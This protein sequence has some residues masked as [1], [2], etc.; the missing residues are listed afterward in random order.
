MTDR[1]GDDRGDPVYPGQEPTGSGQQGGSASY[2]GPPP[3]YPGQ[4]PPPPYGGYGSAPAQPGGYG[5]APVPPGGYGQ[6]PVYP[7]GGYDGA[8]PAAG[9]SGWAIAAFVCSLI[10]FLGILAAVPLAIVALVKISKTRQRGKF[11]AIAAMI[12]SVLW[13]VGAVGL[14]VAWFNNT[15]GRDDQGVI[16]EAG[17]LELQQIRAGDCVEI[18][19]LSDSE[20][21]VSAYEISGLPCDEPHNA[22]AVAVIEIQGEEFPGGAALDA[23]SALLCQ[24]KYSESFPTDF[25]AGVIS[26]RLV[27]TEDVW[28]D[29]G[30]HRS[31][32]F[33]VKSDYSDM[34]G[35]V[36]DR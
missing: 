12:I 18:P 8:A 27:P 33:A 1:P 34:E 14:G 13:W 2:P 23:E 30:G 32:C 15:A 5:Q 11:L 9:W 7:G 6:A 3:S 26:F 35:S 17:R 29:E 4:A 25:P 20:V 24:A 21:E 36:T 10:P 28:N 22:E 19:S 31:I 16:V